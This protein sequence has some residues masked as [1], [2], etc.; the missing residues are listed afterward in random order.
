MNCVNHL[1]FWLIIIH[2]KVIIPFPRLERDRQRK[3]VHSGEF[4]SHGIHS[5][6]Y[7]VRFICGTIHVVQ[8]SSQME[9][10]V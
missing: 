9:H 6:K 5:F 3:W 2:R 8:V 7:I 4:G 10:H 1:K